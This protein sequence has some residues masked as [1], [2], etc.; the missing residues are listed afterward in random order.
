MLPKDVVKA[1]R[2]D[3]S[4]ELAGIDDDSLP[5]WI[6]TRNTI[7]DTMTCTVLQSTAPVQ[8]KLTEKT[9]TQKYRYQCNRMRKASVICFH[10]CFQQE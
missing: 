8:N 9:C 3:F 5:P 6:R 4:R 1:Y 10:N 7:P 2:R